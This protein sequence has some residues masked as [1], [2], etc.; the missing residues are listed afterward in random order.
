MTLNHTPLHPF[1]YR[2]TCSR[3]FRFDF[4]TVAFICP[5]WHDHN[6]FLF[7]LFFFFFSLGVFFVLLACLEP[8]RLHFSLICLVSDNDH[9][10]RAGPGSYNSTLRND[11]KSSERRYTAANWLGCCFYG[12]PVL[13]GSF[14]FPTSAFAHVSRYTPPS[15][16]II[17]LFFYDTKPDGHSLQL[18][19]TIYIYYYIYIRSL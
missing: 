12:F 1:Y 4:S 18:N 6:Y 17:S 11:T 5:W 2:H 8:Q 3:C 19:H 14:Y 7:S 15:S 16:A 13:E 9:W 10:P